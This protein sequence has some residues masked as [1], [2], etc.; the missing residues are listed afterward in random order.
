MPR[1]ARSPPFRVTLI[2]LAVLAA[3][4]AGVSSAPP[5][6]A[7][8]A[9]AGVVACRGMTCLRG[10]VI[11]IQIPNVY[12]VAGI[13]QSGGSYAFSISGECGGGTTTCQFV[14]FWGWYYHFPCTRTPATSAGVGGCTIWLQRIVE[15]ATTVFVCTSTLEIPLAAGAHVCLDAAAE[16]PPG[17]EDCVGEAT[18]S[19]PPP[20][21]GEE[22]GVFLASVS[23]EYR[24]DDQLTQPQEDGACV[25]LYA[26]PLDLP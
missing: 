12:F 8:G 14:Y 22:E 20:P 19:S 11:D 23:Y 6:Q 18:T 4:L 10:D 3:T 13:F 24:L 5:A 1:P 26:R 17:L 9:C 21:C 16:L 7:A 15:D 2:A 25:P